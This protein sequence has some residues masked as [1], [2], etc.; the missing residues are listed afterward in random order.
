MSSAAVVI[1]PLMVKIDYYQY[2]KY[3]GS[4]IIINTSDIQA[5]RT[6]NH[7]PKFTYICKGFTVN[8]L[9]FHTPKFL[10]KWHMQ[11]G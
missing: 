9:K 2:L 8:V 10:T 11:S 7:L 3:S 1:G 6:R 4:K 5:E